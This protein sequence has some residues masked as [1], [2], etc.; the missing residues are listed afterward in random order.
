MKTFVIIK[1][2]AIARGLVGKIIEKFEFMGLR[3][4]KI[5][6]KRK[7]KYWCHSHYAHYAQS[8]ASKDKII[9]EN[10]LDFMVNA[11]LIG[12]VL[13]EKNAISRVRD[14]VGSAINPSLG[15][16]RK[17]FGAKG[18]RN[19]VHASDSEQNVREEI[20][21]FWRENNNVDL[22]GENK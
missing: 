14:M 3:I 2:D 7:N 1:P 19:L 4:K 6:T 5:E 22:F 17:D 13:E 20:E 12:I 10:L 16:I 9:F 11:P 15:T 21:L 8:L 18:V